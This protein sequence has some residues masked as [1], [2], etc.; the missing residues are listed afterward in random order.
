MVAFLHCYCYIR[1]ASWPIMIP[2]YKKSLIYPNF[3]V[4]LRLELRIVIDQ[5]EVSKACV[6]YLPFQCLCFFRA[7]PVR[8]SCRLC[9]EILGLIFSP[10]PFHHTPNCNSQSS[11]GHSPLASPSSVPCPFLKC[12]GKCICPGKDPKT[13]RGT[14]VAELFCNFSLLC[15][16]RLRLL[17]VCLFSG[18]VTL[19]SLV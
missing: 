9:L 17:S 5:R 18:G 15:G 6:Y 10:L 11:S 1:P 8:L 12:A 7:S 2:R 19:Q 16:L 13:L 4:E 14:T 3:R